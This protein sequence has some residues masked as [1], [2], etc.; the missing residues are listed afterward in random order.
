V[1][2]FAGALEYRPGFK[3]AAFG[4]A[5][6]YQEAGQRQRAM[7]AWESYLKLDSTS[8]WAATARRNLRKLQDEPGQ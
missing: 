4:L 8:S 1:V 2:Q 3:R 5:R 6:S 7:T